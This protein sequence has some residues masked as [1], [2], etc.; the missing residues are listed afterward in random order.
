MTFKNLI[1]GLIISF[2]I[3]SC[4]KEDDENTSPDNNN[5]PSQGEP[6]KI[7]AT[8]DTSF[9]LEGKAAI[10]KSPFNTDTSLTIILT[11]SKN[12]DLG[13]SIALETTS[14]AYQ[15]QVLEVDRDFNRSKPYTTFGFFLSKGGA[16]PDLFATSGSLEI[17]D[18]VKDQFIEG[19]LDM[20]GTI[21]PEEK[22]TVSLTGNFKAPLV[23]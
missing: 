20:T 2:A 17:T 4:S 7:E 3:L 15:P 9:T 23:E 21:R 5:N 1:L 19:T 13:G 14:G 12:S 16:R 18:A 22:D 8:G 10:P 6:F 11:S